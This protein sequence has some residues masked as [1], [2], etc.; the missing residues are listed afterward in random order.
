MVPI[1]HSCHSLRHTFAT[2]KAARGV[3]AFQLEEWLGHSS[4]TTSAIYIPL[5]MQDGRKQMEA[6]SL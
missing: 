4:I 6:T 3:S 2:Y 1:A 5:A